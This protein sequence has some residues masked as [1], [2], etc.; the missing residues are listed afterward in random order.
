MRR[1]V[2]TLL[3]V[4]GCWWLAS[5]MAVAFLDLQP[6]L[7]DNLLMVGVVAAFAAV[8]LGLGAWASPGN[9]R[10]ELGL[11]MLIATGVTLF[12]IAS[13]AATVMDRAFMR[14]MPAMPEIHFAPAFGVVNLL[15]IGAVGWWL[16]R[17]ARA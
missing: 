5:E 17:G 15:V 12:M 6:G 8:A 11:T 13:V 2:A 14:Y 3:L 4:I 16:Y 9:R 7:A 1:F 10:R